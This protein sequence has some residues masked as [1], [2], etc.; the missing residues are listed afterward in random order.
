MIESAQ[1]SH[2]VFSARYGH[3]ISGILDIKSKKGDSSLSFLELGASSSAANMNLSHPINGAGSFSAMLKATYWAPVIWAAQGLSAYI[4]DEEL[5]AVNAI[6][7]APYILSGTV[8]ADYRF[9]PDFSASFNAFLGGDGG[10]VVYENPSNAEG[11]EGYTDIGA[12]WL[13][14]VGFLTGGLLWNPRPDMAVG[15]RLGAGFSRT[16]MD[17]RIVNS[18]TA[19]YT[20]EFINDFDG[21]T[22]LYPPGTLISLGE[23]YTVDNRQTMFFGDETDTVQARLDVDWDLKNGFFVAGGIQEQYSRWL[24]EED[25]WFTM[26]TPGGILT[27]SSG[28]QKTLYYNYPV[29]TSISADN[30]A[31][32]T[33]GYLTGEWTS[34]SGFF[35]TELGI[36][37]DSFTFLG[38]DFSVKSS[39][40]FNP[41]LNM[42]FHV[43]RNR[44][45]VDSLTLTLGTGLFSSMTDSL[46]DMQK[47]E[48]DDYELKPNRSWTSI[49]G[50]HFNFLGAWTLNIEAYYKQVF[51]RGYR[52]NWVDDS[53]A[54]TSPRYYF[55]GE[56]TVWGADVMLHKRAGRF[57]DGW[58]TYTFT[59][60][61]YAEPGYA[62]STESTYRADGYYPSF[63]RFHNLNLILNIKPQD[64]FHIYIRY[65]FASGQPKSAVGAIDYYPVAILDENHQPG[66]IIQ[67]YKRNS[68]Y[69]DDLRTTPSMPF[70]IKCSWFFF[71]QRGRTTGEFYI[72]LENI[73]SL[74]YNSR[75]N[76]SFNQ[77]TGKE[78]TGS[79]QA[80]YEL[81]I[82]VPSMGYKWSF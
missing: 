68:Y 66:Q 8:S 38:K 55:D 50:A 11:Y 28:G 12:E 25:M 22:L 29:N 27:T 78:D 1:L 42:N 24:R 54:N 16:D 47:D 2:G 35:D 46:S 5:D 65:G 61:R 10:G 34:P 45:F 43:I 75:A 30:H 44:D 64:Q 20:Q 7:L 40:A 15:L 39:P 17:A 9:T 60:A 56:G 49:A 14:S 13:N 48:V 69:S 58:I 77:Y 71:N 32:S 26:E 41:R 81:P 31:F 23:R 19:P 36:R 4:D 63:H 37:L 57:V 70:D 73:A 62:S 3:T 51:S 80:I 53:A 82:P 52:I 74:F 76:T 59:Y 21:Q 18:I 6:T 67:K 72:A 33:S 79:T